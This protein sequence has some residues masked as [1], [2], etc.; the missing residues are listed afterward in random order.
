[1]IG[2]KCFNST[3]VII[4]YLHLFDSFDSKTTETLGK[5]L[6][7]W[8]KETEP[9]FIKRLKHTNPSTV[10]VTPVKTLTSTT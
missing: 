7:N 3:V 10:E 6:M 8:A 9:N 1:M 2:L 5:T 4:D